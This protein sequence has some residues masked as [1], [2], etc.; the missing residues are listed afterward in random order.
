MALK[1][2]IENA[3]GLSRSEDVRR[4][5]VGVTRART[6]RAIVSTPGARLHITRDHRDPETA[7][8]L[9]WCVRNSVAMELV[10]GTPAVIL[11]GRRVT[12]IEAREA[13]SAP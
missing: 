1:D 7:R 8:L 6:N 3:L 10:E 2:I 5:P 13:L 9:L 4:I 11:D 12:A